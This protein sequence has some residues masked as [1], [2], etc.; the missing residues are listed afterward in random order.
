[1]G[2]ASKCLLIYSIVCLGFIAAARNSN[3]ANPL[4]YPVSVT[5]G[6]TFANIIWSTDI[7][8][9]S[10]VD[11]GTTTAYGSS[12]TDGTNV[13]W[14]KLTLAGLNPNTTYHYSVISGGTVSNDYTFTTYA[15]PSGT[16]RT[17]GTGKTYSTIQACANAASGGDTCLVYSGSYGAVSSARNGSSGNPITF[18]AQEPTTVSGWRLSHT[19]QSIK[20]FELTG[21]INGSLSHNAT[22][23]NNYIHPTGGSGISIADGSSESNNIIIRKNTVYMGDQNSPSVYVF[24]NRILIESN[25]IS[26]GA[27]FIDTG[28]LTTGTN[29]VIRNNV[30]HH[31]SHD[32]IGGSEHIDGLQMI[33]GSTMSTSLIEGNVEYSCADSTGNC[34]FVQARVG[35]APNSDTVIVRYNYAYS[36]AGLCFGFGDNSDSSYIYNWMVY[37]NTCAT[38]HQINEN[39]D[40]IGWVRA[41]G[42]GKNNIFYK[43]VAN[44]ASPIYGGTGNNYN[45]AYNPGYSGSWN[46][47]YSAEAT[48]NTLKNVNPT[49]VNY[50][51]NPTLASNSPAIDAGGPLTTVSS[52]CSGSATSIVVGD[53]HYFQAGWTG[54]DW[55][56]TLPDS[57]AVGTVN[58]RVQI[59]SINYSNNTI[60]LSNAISC[61]NGNSVW[62]YRKSD[63]VQVLYGTAPD[64]GAYEYSGVSGASLAPPT[65][66]RIVN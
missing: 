37:N 42:T 23:E 27:D 53:A 49:F 19:Y 31:T 2:K 13:T 45:I 26:H 5:V 59:G 65:N 34:H 11:Y 15:N 39:G 6:V 63:G 12:L 52:G 41:T 21:G 54:T 61:S 36:I 35:S 60:G 47:P 66:L 32:V 51:T 10:R 14:H 7:S 62:L 48:Y 17:V 58:N 20:G 44:G 29:I 40:G 9:N 33:G 30:L 50:P 57:I 28:S 56:G 1:M 22:I 43:T 18:L 8:A 4:I 55:V 16:I 3:A 24:G 25:D 46:S 64:I 38:E